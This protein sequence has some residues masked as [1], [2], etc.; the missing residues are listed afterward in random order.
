MTDTGS[1]TSDTW[2]CRSL[3][4]SSTVRGQFLDRWPLNQHWLVVTSE[5][6]AVFSETTL[7]STLN[8]VTSV[9]KPRIRRNLGPSVP[10]R[11]FC[12]FPVV[13]A[14]VVQSSYIGCSCCWK[15]V[16]LSKLRVGSDEGGGGGLGWVKGYVKTRYTRW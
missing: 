8:Y 5:R 4:S 15:L 3:K 14:N 6:E 10:T 16:Q 2:L 13:L 1:C 12:S 9:L 11:V 7:V